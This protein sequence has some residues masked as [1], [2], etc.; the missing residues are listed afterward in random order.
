[1]YIK[2]VNGESLSIFRREVFGTGELE[3]IISDTGAKLTTQELLI[4]QPVKLSVNGDYAMTMASQVTIADRTVATV[5]SVV[6]LKDISRNI[7]GVNP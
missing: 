5:I 6:S 7:V 2:P 4:G 1:L 3:T